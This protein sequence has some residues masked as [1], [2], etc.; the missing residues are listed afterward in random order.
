MKNLNVFH[1]L[2]FLSLICGA[3]AVWQRSPEPP[4]SSALERKEVTLV[5]AQPG[6]VTFAGHRGGTTLGSWP[7]MWVFVVKMA[8]AE[9]RFAIDPPEEPR[10]RRLQQME[11]RN[12]PVIAWVHDDHIWQLENPAGEV[13]VPYE[14]RAAERL[15]AIEQH[16]TAEML[17]FAVGLGLLGA[18]YGMKWLA[19]ALAR[20]ARK[21]RDFS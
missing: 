17:F 3:V 1:I 9:H 6:P 12:T 15:Q 19:H 14:Y 18:A 11:R 8:P 13:L 20:P 2:G 16:T 21:P 5:L 7:G 4:G 10:L